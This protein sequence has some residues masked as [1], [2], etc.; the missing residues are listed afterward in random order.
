MNFEGSMLNLENKE[1]R[2]HTRRPAK[3]EGAITEPVKPKETPEDRAVALMRNSR[4][5]KEWDDN[6]DKIKA[7]NNGNYPEWWNE[8]IISSGIAAETQLLW[9]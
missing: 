5:E 3:Q 7:A 2:E 9:K 8:K 1:G 6:C 4:S